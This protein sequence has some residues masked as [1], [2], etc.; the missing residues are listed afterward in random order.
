MRSRIPPRSLRIGLSA[1]ISDHKE[2]AKNSLQHKA[3]ICSPQQITS[4]GDTQSQSL[5]TFSSKP[6]VLQEILESLVT[7]FLAFLG[8]GFFAFLLVLFIPEMSFLFETFRDTFNIIEKPPAAYPDTGGS[9][10][11][12]I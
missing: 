8:T 2:A 4:H 7:T 5:R 10:L 6:H 9:S 1:G 12:F 3:T 11:I